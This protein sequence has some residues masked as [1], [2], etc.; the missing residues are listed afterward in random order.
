MTVAKTCLVIDAEKT[1][2]VLLDGPALRITMK[3]QS[4]RLFPLRRVARIHVIGQVE[5]SF[6]AMVACA[7]KQIPVAFFT[8][9]GKLRCQLYYPIFENGVISHWFE[10]V[11]FDEEAKRIYSEWLACQ[12]LNLL[13]YMGFKKCSSG[14]RQQLVVETLNHH[15]KKYWA[16][17]N[18]S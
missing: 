12:T 15:C 2:H 7:E 6:D 14:I 3:C 4:P 18:L 8:K 11:E 17:K 16:I 9:Q 5:N 1:S 13:A 10:H